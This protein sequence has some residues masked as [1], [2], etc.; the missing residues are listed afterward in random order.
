MSYIYINFC[1]GRI[2]CMYKDYLYF[3]V[4]MRD[5]I[6]KIQIS[7]TSVISIQISFLTD[8]AINCIEKLGLELDKFAIG[9]SVN[10]IDFSIKKSEINKVNVEHCKKIISMLSKLVNVKTISIHPSERLSAIYEYIILES[11]VTEL[12]IV[13]YDDYDTNDKRN[14]MVCISNT[15]KLAGN[16]SSIRRIEFVG[17]SW[18]HVKEILGSYPQL[19]ELVI[20]GRDFHLLEKLTEEENKKVCPNLKKVIIGWGLFSASQMRTV[21]E[22]SRNNDHMKTLLFNRVEFQ[23]GAL[24]CLLD[25]INQGKMSHIGEFITANCTPD[26]IKEPPN[27]MYTIKRTLE[28]RKAGVLL[29]SISKRKGLGLTPSNVHRLLELLGLN[30]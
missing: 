17:A 6:E 14:G 24:E 8:E 3:G 25:D 29:S 9:G 22:W 4:W 7:I 11:R 13:S 10:K 5:V 27:T 23:P 12:D 1:D 16:K 30:K 21:I 28:R 15:F 2:H 19:E 20:H 26:A 18:G